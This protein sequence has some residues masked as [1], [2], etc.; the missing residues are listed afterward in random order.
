MY[1][2]CNK[3][4]ACSRFTGDQDRRIARRDFGDARENTLQ[5]GRR[6]NDLFKHRGFVDFFTQSDVFLLESLFNPF[7]VVDVNTRDIPTADLSPLVI[8]RVETREKPSK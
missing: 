8:E 1:G 3:L 5:S 6:S 2:A 7:A 4:F